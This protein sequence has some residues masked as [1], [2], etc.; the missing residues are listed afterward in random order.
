MLASSQADYYNFELQIVWYS[1][2]GPWR[3]DHTVHSSTITANAK[4]QI[5]CMCVCETGNSWYTCFTGIAMYSFLQT[6]DCCHSSWM[7][8][9]Q[10][11]LNWA[12]YSYL[13]LYLSYCVPL[14][15]IGSLLTTGRTLGPAPSHQH[16]RCSHCPTS[17]RYCI[18]MYQYSLGSKC[19]ASWMIIIHTYI[20]VHMLAIKTC[21]LATYST[22]LADYYYP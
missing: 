13:A 11:V 7:V 6:N 20:T 21:T 17:E 19:R 15:S 2:F 1:T 8:C 3:Q 16:G 10:R 14:C 9:I 18:S 12:R 4:V 22:L 5:L